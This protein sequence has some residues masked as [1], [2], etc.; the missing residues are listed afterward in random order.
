ML[1]FG[2][3]V[4]L[5]QQFFWYIVIH[6][7]LDGLRFSQGP[8][9]KKAFLKFV[10]HFLVEFVMQLFL[11]NSDMLIPNPPHS[12][13]YFYFFLLKLKNKMAAKRAD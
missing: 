3:Y 7:S 1:F 6:F 11:H 9:K 10:S 4:I 12:K 2:V 5:D 13:L 8:L